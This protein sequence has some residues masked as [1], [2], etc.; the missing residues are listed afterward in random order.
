MLNKDKN[1]ATTTSFAEADTVALK[2]QIIIS[3]NQIKNAHEYNYI[4][5]QY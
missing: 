4:L 1:I 2:F 5:V 3:N